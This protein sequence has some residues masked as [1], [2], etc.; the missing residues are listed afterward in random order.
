MYREIFA[1][2]SPTAIEK[3]ELCHLV[4]YRKEAPGRMRKIQVNELIDVFLSYRSDAY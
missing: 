4:I 2:E 3:L 1:S